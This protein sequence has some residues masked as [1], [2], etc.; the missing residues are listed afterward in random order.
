MAVTRAFP[1][2]A[3]GFVGPYRLFGRL[4]SGGMGEVYEGYDERLDRRVAL[5]R[6]R[7]DA[8]QPERARRR[9]SREARALARVVHPAIVQVHD[10]VSAAAPPARATAAADLTASRPDRPRARGL[11]TLLTA[12]VPRRRRLA[13]A[14]TVSVLLLAVVGLDVALRSPGE[15]TYVAVPETRIVAPGAA[16]EDLELAAGAV[17]TALLQGLLGFREIAALE[18]TGPEAEIEDPVVLARAVAA[19]EALASR[20]ECGAGS[21]CRVVISRLQAGDGRVLRTAGFTVETDRFLELSLAVLG[22]MGGTYP[23]FRRR[24][25]DLRLEVRP[26]D[27]EVYLRLL[28]RF[29]SREDGFSGAEVLNGLETLQRSSPRFPALPI[30]EAQ[31]V[32]WRFKEERDPADLERARPG[33]RARSFAGAGRSP[34]LDP[35]S[36]ARPRRGTDRRGAS[37]A[38]GLAAPRAGQRPAIDGAGASARRKGRRAGAAAGAGGLRALRGG[39]RRLHRRKTGFFRSAEGGTLFLDEIGE[40]PVEVQ[41]LLLRALENPEIQPVGSV[42]TRRVDVRVIAATDSDLDAAIAQGRFRAPLLHRLEG[43]RDPP[44]GAVLRSLSGRSAHR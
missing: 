23:G 6:V 34:G 39:A 9:F 17:R 33:D 5:K 37:G 28:R 3:S 20:L 43:L 14:L 15:P 38:R 22:H 40:V 16:T 1:E 25:D 44:A 19:D 4:G 36:A 42:E 26:A 27:Y 41:A 12:A 18:P 32:L 11:T 8:G 29:K 30:L 10:W 31:V 7:P 2:T 24:R 13:A 21:T 35:A